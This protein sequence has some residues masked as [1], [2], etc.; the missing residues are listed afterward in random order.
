MANE[1]I[2]E[3]VV[4]PVSG[5]DGSLLLSSS[6]VFLP[7]AS[8][9]DLLQSSPDVALVGQGGRLQTFAVRGLSKERIRVL[10]QGAPIRALRRAGVSAA[11]LNP[12]WV[13]VAAEPRGAGTRQGTGAVGG[14]IHTAPLADGTR[15]LALSYEGP[16]RHRALDLHASAG[17]WTGAL[18]FARRQNQQAADGSKLNTSFE[19]LSSL[20]SRRLNLGAVSG[21]TTLLYSEGRDLGKSNVRFPERAA[22]YPLD[23]HL[24]LAQELEHD[25]LGRA[26]AWIHSQRL[27]TKTHR[28]GLR[29]DVETSVLDYG[30]RY[31][32]DRELGGNRRMSWGADVFGRS[33]FDIEENNLS[34]VE[35][36]EELELGLFA[37]LE[38]RVGAWRF[39]V[40]SRGVYGRVDAHSR[41]AYDSGKVLGHLS[42]GHRR[43]SHF[44][45]TFA[46][47]RGATLPTVSQLF[48]SGTT[49]R[50]SVVGNDELD[51]EDVW[52][53]ELSASGRLGAARWLLNGFLADIDS[54][55]DKVPLASDVDRFV[56]GDGGE[57]Y[58]FSGELAYSW[59]SLLL[60]AG[61]ATLRG[62]LDDGTA[63]RDLPANRAMIRSRWTTRLGTAAVELEQ[64]FES[65]RVAPGNQRED[66]RTLVSLS[67]SRRLSD[68]WSL[69]LYGRNLLDEL[70]VT[71]NDA[72]AP[73]G[74]E[75]T[76]GVR[77]NA[78]L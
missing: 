55:I 68:R 27:E 66:A 38:Q 24:F 57:V 36:G 1:P 70:Y 65:D 25:R 26:S 15:Q 53:Y 76:F 50:G 59:D 64:R 44:G 8:L 6:R 77:L 78:R 62:E 2:E 72:Q 12:G 35:D 30:L 23:R 32:G 43:S 33:N 11:F 7:P 73:F 14:V 63:M 49:G 31:D 48:F 45:W 67:L 21:Q 74:T 18:A 37:E 20:L 69:T 5:S 4:R 34:A 52:I 13:S 19:Q 42:V 46:L 16:G 61:F 51:A 47:Q 54:L 17:P 3:I 40:G 39:G 71:S 10:F 58:G 9:T 29:T 28:E 60:E 56:N 22:S 41:R 75:R